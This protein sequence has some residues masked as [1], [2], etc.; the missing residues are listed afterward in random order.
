MNKF[1][2]T[3]TFIFQPVFMILLLLKF[4]LFNEMIS[5]N[6]NI[7][8]LLSNMIITLLLI[9]FLNL[10]FVGNKYL[11]MIITFTFISILLFANIVYFSYFGDFITSSSLGNINQLPSVFGS[12]LQVIKK[13]YLF[14]LM[15][16]PLVIYLS[17]SLRKPLK[18]FSL[19]LNIVK[20]I[21]CI[22][23]ISLIFHKVFTRDEDILKAEF[24]KQSVSNEVGILGMYLN[25]EVK[26]VVSSP[27][28]KKI[29]NASVNNINSTFKIVPI[30]NSKY[31]GKN[32][33][34]IQ[35]ESLQD[36]V[37]NKQY[38]AKEIT[39]S[40]NKLLK[41]SA[42]FNN[43]YYQIGYGHTADAEMIANTSL[44][45]FGD[46]CAYTTKSDNTFIGLSNY[47]KGLNYSTYAFHGNSATYWNRLD[48]YKK[49]QFDNFYSSE[50]LKRE[51]LTGMG[52]SDLSFFNQSF[53]ILKDKKSPFYA[54]AITLTSHSP[55]DTV[56]DFNDKKN[57]ME[58]YYNSI[59]YAD[60]ALGEFID[61][62]STNGLLDNSILV[63]YGDHNAFTLS[64]NSDLTTATGENTY[65][66]YNWQKYQKVPLI[67]RLPDKEHAGKTFS[68]SVGQMDILP[69]LA[70]LLEIPDVKAFGE[71]VFDFKDHLVVLRNG[72]YVFGKT[73]YNKLEN[74]TFNLETGAIVKNS[75]SLIKASENKL[76]A[77]DDIFK[78]DLLDE[79][80]DNK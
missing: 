8:Q 3:V 78:Y 65:V 27:L 50:V 2:K 73:Y 30:N 35:V 40:L 75:D 42:Y 69:T 55:F 20:I 63:I 64:N 14:F 28:F 60:K 25:K 54:F 26:S 4:S 29:D 53:D 74:K 31:A 66:N 61:K 45:P 43:T 59:N 17:L 5:G 76:K 10:L 9:Y 51:S 47:L 77:S 11:S 79:L 21:L 13:D 18:F 46:N 56:N 71:N 19:K 52:I 57:F 67:I 32:L 15:D 41:D 12:T 70:N 34:M 58:N 44:F 24:S 37:I 48:I 38:N 7:Y 72:D 62:L 1:E 36:F 68:N 33:I 39:P 16:I 22:C 49:L 80:I 23:C 6:I